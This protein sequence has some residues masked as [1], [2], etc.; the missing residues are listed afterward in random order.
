MQLTMMASITHFFKNEWLER[1]VRWVCVCGLL[2]VAAV[3][4]QA[5]NTPI[6]SQLSVERSEDDILLSAQV[7]FELPSAVEDA[8]MKGMPLN[9]VS[10]VEVLRERWYWYDKKIAQAERRLRL[11][12]QPLT[13]RW[14]LTV[15]SG[16]AKGGALGLS[17]NQNFETL[18]QA[19]STIKRIS[20]WKIADTA[21]L[22]PAVDY[23]VD[24]RFKLDLSQLPLP[25]QIGTL[26]QADWNVA[27]SLQTPFSLDQSK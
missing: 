20:R 7:Q 21:G 16:A 4:V 25:L 8:L 1:V 12:Y 13:R 23:R 11:A 17:L 19:L 24:Y 2:L 9:F 18:S 14:R 22:D 15:T 27:V 10:E 3:A 6:P 26:G 5:Q